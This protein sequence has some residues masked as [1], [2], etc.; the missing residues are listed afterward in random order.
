[1]TET[2]VTRVITGLILSAIIWLVTTTSALVT[3]VGQ[4]EVHIQNG[5]EADARLLAKQGSLGEQVA[6]IDSEVN[7]L[8]VSIGIIIKNQD[9]M[10]AKLDANH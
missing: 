9:R 1:M 4:Q 3:T 7:G 5:I 8:S 2:S 6:A 10:L